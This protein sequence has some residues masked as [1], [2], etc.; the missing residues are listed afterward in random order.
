MSP[1]GMLLEEKVAVITGGA[2]GIGRATAL[3]FASHGAHVIVGDVNESGGEETVEDIKKD[4]S[5]AHFFRT[6]VSR[7]EE[8]QHLMDASSRAAGGIDVIVNNAGLQYAGVVTEFEEP[9]WDALMQVNAKSC[10]LSAKYG[11]PHL[12]ARGGGSIVCN[13]SLGGIRGGAGLTAYSASKG[14]I[15]AFTKA[16]AQEVAGD[17]IRVNCV[18]PGWIDTP[19]NQPAID[20]MGGRKNQDEM[21]QQKVPMQRQGNPKEVAN[22]ILFLASD[23]SSYMTA[24]ALIISGGSY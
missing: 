2:S 18:A 20:F 19:F 16:L 6:D 10:F 22:V 21:V 9:R 17:G 4:G 15:V 12:R 1:D 23:A 11:V 5:S 7:A 8:M 13:S 24:Q 14:A 3:L